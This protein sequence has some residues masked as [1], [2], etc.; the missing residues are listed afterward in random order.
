M[1]GVWVAVAA[2]VLLRLAV[3]AAFPH[4]PLAGDEE[5]YTRAAAA[6]LEGRQDPWLL[7]HPPL[8]TLLCAGVQALTGPS[9]NA[10]RVVQAVL[11]GASVLGLALLARRAFGARAALWAAWIYALNPEFIAYSHYLWSECLQLALL[12]WGLV[13]LLALH[14][15]PSARRAVAAGLLWGVASLVKPYSLYLFP[16][17]LAGLVAWPGALRGARG[18]RLS[19]LALGVCVLAIVPWSIHAS[20]EVGRPVVICTV[21][22]LSLETGLNYLPA[23]QFDFGSP[24]TTTGKLIRGASQKREEGVVA[25][26]LHNPGLYLSRAVEKLSYLWTPNSYVLRC[27]YVHDKYGP[28][29]ELSALF[30]LGVVWVLLLCNAALTVGLIVGLAYMGMLTLTPSFSRYRMP[31]MIFAVVFSAAWLAGDARLDARGRRPVATTLAA[32]ATLAL[33]LVWIVRLPPVIEL[34]W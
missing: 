24:P 14:E 16:F 4:M 29:A 25:F 32:A 8:Y 33:L 12:I 28:P 23:P 30:R 34:A 21:S 13:A 26:I 15:R 17:L 9:E 11:E 31:L 5:D 6:L 18:L 3:V 19:A 7:G 27:L 22:S 10:I 1:K 20:R 2:A